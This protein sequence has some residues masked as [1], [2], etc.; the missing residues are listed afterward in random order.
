M[1]AWLGIY[2]NR[3]SMTKRSAKIRSSQI[4]AMINTV[5]SMLGMESARALDARKSALALLHFVER[6]ILI[7]FD[8]RSAALKLRSDSCH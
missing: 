1:S 5:L 8:A 7:L 6:R 4:F 3:N 2:K